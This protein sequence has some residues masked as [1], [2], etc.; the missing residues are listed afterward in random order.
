MRARQLRRAAA[1]LALCAALCTAAGLAAAQCVIAKQDSVAVLGTWTGNNGNSNDIID[2]SDY[3]MIDPSSY[4]GTSNQWPSPAVSFRIGTASAG[5]IDYAVSGCNVIWRL[6]VAFLDP[7]AGPGG[8]RVYTEV[9]SGTLAGNLPFEPSGFTLGGTWTVS[10]VVEG[11]CVKGVSPPQGE[12]VFVVRAANMANTQAKL[13]TQTHNQAW[14]NGDSPWFL[15]N[16]INREDNG[17]CSVNCEAIQITPNGFFAESS[18]G[19]VGVMQV[20]EQVHPDAFDTTPVAKNVYWNFD[21]N[22]DYGMQLLSDVQS[23]AYGHWD[24]DVDAAC[25]AANGTPTKGSVSGNETCSVQYAP[26]PQAAYNPGGVCISQAW[27]DL[28]WIKDYNQHWYLD[29]D[30]SKGGWFRDPEG[31]GSQG[32]KDYVLHVCAE[33]SLW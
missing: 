13:S 3:T 27:R 25:R 23:D 31:D 5:G 1:R 26:P 4:P 24:T 28:E 20:N 15:P 14:L 32:D 2:Q 11:L 17:T 6:Q 16:L 7:A 12:L 29:F 33:S 9:A 8:T 21:T 30:T 19:D 22:I 18:S 10:A